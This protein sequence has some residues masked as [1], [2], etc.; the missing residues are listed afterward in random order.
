MVLKGSGQYRSKIALPNTEIFVFKFS[1][2][3]FVSVAKNK[4]VKMC[5]TKSFPVR[6]LGASMSMKFVSDRN[7]NYAG[8]VANYTTSMYIFLFSGIILY[9]VLGKG[10]SINSYGFFYLHNVQI[11]ADPPTHPSMCTITKKNTYK[12]EH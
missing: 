10:P 7:K 8:F 11:E 12:F 6:S 2:T 4:T 3:I 5:G 9:I 1:S